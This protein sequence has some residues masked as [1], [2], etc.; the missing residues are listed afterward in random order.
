[1]RCTG[2][3]GVRR[4]RWPAYTASTFVDEVPGM[5]GRHGAA[6][7]SSDGPRTARPAGHVETDYLAFGET[8]EAAVT[9]VHALTLREVRAHLDACL[10][11]E[12]EAGEPGP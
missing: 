1:M 8:R 7:A 3:P 11:R 5:D 9:A 10:A 12:R 2:A 4:E 6:L